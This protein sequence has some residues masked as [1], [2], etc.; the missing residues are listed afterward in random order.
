MQWGHTRCAI[1][2]LGG[3]YRSLMPVQ[4]RSVMA[5]SMSLD[6]KRA[7]TVERSPAEASFCKKRSSTCGFTWPP[8]R[9]TWSRMLSVTMVCIP[10]DVSHISMLQFGI[11]ARSSASRSS[12]VFSCSS[13]ACEAATR[14]TRVA[15]CILFKLLDLSTLGVL[16]SLS[17][18]SPRSLSVSVT[19]P[20]THSSFS[21]D[22]AQ[23]LPFIKSIFSCSMSTSRSRSSACSCSIFCSSCDACLD[24]T[25]SSKTLIVAASSSCLRSSIR[26]SSPSCSMRL[27]APSRLVAR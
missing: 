13:L 20:E 12:A 2:A 6:R 21:D 22:I 9:R 18:P 5:S 1:R 15:V 23:G 24:E 17:S 27:H 14:A 16:L 10:R 4:S 26:M 7:S 11:A 8:E 19:I 3:A 25:R